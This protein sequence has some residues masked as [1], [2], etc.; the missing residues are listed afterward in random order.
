MIRFLKCILPIVAILLLAGC[1]PVAGVAPSRD[2][3]DEVVVFAAASLT[4]VFTALGN[5][6]AQNHSPGRAVFNFAGSQQLASQLEQGAQADVFASADERQMDGVVDAA[7]ID[8]ADVRVFA[9]NRL[10]V[11]TNNSRVDSLSKLAEPGFKI[12]VGAE[13]VPVGAYALAFL[14]AAA[15]DPVYGEAF[16]DG[17]LANVVSYEQNVRAVLSKV[18]LGE[19]DAGIVYATD[20]RTAPE[21]AVLEIPAHLNQRAIYQI[22][23]VR[24]GP[25]PELAGQFVDFLT[26][27]TGGRLLTE[28]GFSTDCAGAGGQPTP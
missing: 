27:P 17:V 14:A 3:P 5:A 2:A 16:R 22:A 25:S 15:A 7:R 20:T 9:C 10:V 19:A 11:V 26:S 28:A 6:F 13:A 4:E 23:A 12:V 21:V 8:R 18:R 1:V 24:D